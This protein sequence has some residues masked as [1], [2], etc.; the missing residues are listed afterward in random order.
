MDEKRTRFLIRLIAV[1]TAGTALY[2]LLPTHW[3]YWWEI[4]G[5]WARQGI[6][7]FGR[8]ASWLFPTMILFDLILLF[9]LVTAYGL[10]RLRS[11]AIIPAIC[12][13]SLDFILRL[14]GAINMWT[15]TL[16]HPEL[17]PIPTEG[18][19]VKVISM[20]PSY[21]IGTISLV[22]LIILFRKSVREVCS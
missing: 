8:H 10:F 14:C 12:V 5:L 17:P 15:Y 11:W 13:L 21:I 7:P 22:S 3:K 20:W 19:V 1:G 6:S 9:K 16:R 2:A 4:I 18:V